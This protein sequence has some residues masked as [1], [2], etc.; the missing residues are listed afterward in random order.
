MSEKHTM[1]LFFTTDLENDNQFSLEME[2]NPP[3]EQNSFRLTADNIF[4][5]LRQQQQIE[6]EKQNVREKPKSF[7]T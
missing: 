3:I 6:Q 7:G 5:W 1:T 2:A 4:R